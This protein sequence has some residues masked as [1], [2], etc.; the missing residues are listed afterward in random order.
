MYTKISVLTCSLKLVL[1]VVCVFPRVGVASRA[2]SKLDW[3]NKP[4]GFLI[5]CILQRPRGF[6]LQRQRYISHLLPRPET[7]RNVPLCG[8][9]R[10]RYNSVTVAPDRPPTPKISV[11]L[12]CR[13]QKKHRTGVFLAVFYNLLGVIFLHNFGWNSFVSALFGLGANKTT[14]IA[15]GSNE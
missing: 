8:R 14:R 9:Q 6:S 3:L 4:G 13:Q 10:Q 5:R 11:T 12:P 1:L 2:G 15:W 7:I